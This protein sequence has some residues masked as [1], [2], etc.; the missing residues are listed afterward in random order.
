MVKTSPSRAGG[1]GLIP[2]WGAKIPCAS[3]PKKTQNIKQRQY[4]NTFNKDVKWST[5]CEHAIYLLADPA[6][7]IHCLAA[8]C[9]CSVSQLCPT[10]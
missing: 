8:S 1:M 10:L 6:S 2:G 9:W 5:Q 4:C 3:W 7:Y